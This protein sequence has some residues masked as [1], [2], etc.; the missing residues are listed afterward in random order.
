VEAVHLGSPRPG[1]PGVRSPLEHGDSPWSVVER[2]FLG[3]VASG[4]EPFTTGLSLP[5]RLDPELLLPPG[6]KLI[7]IHTG[8]S[9]SVAVARAA[10]SSLR[11]LAIQDETD[12]WVSAG[13]RPTADALAADVQRL[14]APHLPKERLAVS[15]WHWREKSGATRSCRLVAV[16]SWQEVEANYPHASRDRLRAL[17]AMERPDEQGRLILW[18]GEPGTGKTRAMMAIANE[19]SSWCDLHVITD[20]ERMFQNP[21][22]LLEVLLGWS[23]VAADG[24]GRRWKLVVAEDADEYLRSDARRRSGPALGRLLNATDGIVGLGTG[25]VILLTTNDDVGRLHPAVTR[26][27]RCLAVVEFPRF[28][29]REASDWLGADA[30]P[31]TRP[32]TLAELYQLR[33]NTP[34]F[35]EAEEPVSEGMYL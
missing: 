10:R 7:R 2:E 15:L 30:D 1:L 14:A 27:G 5:R 11:I 17:S 8:P 22:Y 21:Q 23:E 31:P 29:P 3:H 12:V 6:F 32:L 33:T 26:P 9:H 24:A 16:Q 28:S 35:G 19:W 34:S 4:E 25:A 13:S 18:Y 20:P